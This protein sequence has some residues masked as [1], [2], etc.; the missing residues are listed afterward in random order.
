MKHFTFIITLAIFFSLTSYSQIA[1]K[2]Q[3]IKLSNIDT[4]ELFIYESK[5]AK[6]YFSQNDILTYFEK[7]PSDE[8]IIF[9]QFIDTL[10]ANT[11]QIHIFSD[12]IYDAVFANKLNATN[13]SETLPIEKDIRDYISS[14]F[15]FI[16]AELMLK[17]KFLLYSKKQKK[18]ITKH[19]KVRKRN[20][21]LGNKFLVF[22]FKNKETFYEVIFSLGE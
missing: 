21:N 1:Y 11:N 19:I 7:L 9:A 3:R 12:T 2:K 20:D 22:N 13:P 10:I 15:M 18:F 4:T 8:K 6:L 14:S 5:N 17:G 16:A